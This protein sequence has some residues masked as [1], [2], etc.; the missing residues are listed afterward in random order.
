MS[1]RRRAS[2]K[3]LRMLHSS[4]LIGF[5]VVLAASA[6]VWGVVYGVL[7]YLPERAFG[8]IRRRDGV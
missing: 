3:A 8:R 5:V 2:R 7:V 6:L 1:K 4:A